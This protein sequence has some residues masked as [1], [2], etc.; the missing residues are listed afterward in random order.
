MQDDCSSAPGVTREPQSGFAVGPSADH[1]LRDKS[2][3]QRKLTGVL[4]QP[5]T[6]APHGVILVTCTF[7]S[8]YW[9]SRIQRSLAILRDKW[10][11]RGIFGDR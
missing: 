8:L 2:G 3:G 6:A 4:L 7:R 9:A 10:C 5:M 11:D 1:H